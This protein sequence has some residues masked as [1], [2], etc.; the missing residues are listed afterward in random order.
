MDFFRR[1][2]L[3]TKIIT[4]TFLMIFFVVIAAA[5]AIDRVILPSIEND[6]HSEAWRIAN[7]VFS[8]LDGTFDSGNENIWEKR[9]APVFAV[10]PKLLYVEILQFR[11]R[12]LYWAGDRKYRDLPPGKP[13][14]QK[15]QDTLSVKEIKPTGLIYEIV[16]YGSKAAPF[17]S[18]WH[19]RVGVNATVLQQ[20]STQLFRVLFGLTLILLLVSFFLIRWFSGMITRP[21]H[22]LLHMTRL[23]AREPPE[24]ISRFTQEHPPCW[25]GK[26]GGFSPL[27]DSSELFCP[28][29]PLFGPAGKTLDD[30][31]RSRSDALCSNCTVYHQVGRDE[32]SQLLFTFQCMAAGIRVYQEKLKKRYEFEERLLD[33]CPDGIMANDRHG[34][35]ILYNR[36]AENLL[37]YPAEE[38]VNRLSVTAIYRHGEP[39]RIKETLMGETHGGPGVLLDYLTEI[40]RKDGSVVPIRLSATIVPHEAEE[41]AVVG[42][43]HDLTEV[44]HHMNALRELNQR[45]DSSNRELAHLNRHYMEMLGFVTHELK[46]PIAN[47]FM[48]ANA[49]RQEIFGPLSAEQAPMLTSICRNLTQSMEMIR[50]YLDLSRIEKDELPIQP[51]SV[52]L[53]TEI[54]EPVVNGF[55]SR[56]KER[57]TSLL[58]EV[59]EDLRWTL[60]PELFSGVLTNLLSNALNYG[61]EGGTI[62]ISARIME[63]CLR[64]EV[65]NS[66]PGI[67]RMDLDRL[68]KKFQRLPAVRSSLT[69]GTGLGLFITKA[70]VERHGGSI[71]AESEP[72]KWANFIIELPAATPLS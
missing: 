56:L 35:I 33:A 17:E 6:L 52:S 36:G 20:W 30:H 29:C 49:L 46:A 61:E 50:H 51:R 42:Y 62:R 13:T 14:V 59:A 38:V 69:R 68:F 32:L 67:P 39:Q 44:T 25:S 27:S 34:T 3:Q 22:Q 58:I 70:V 11:D 24:N 7:G 65:W 64:I 71:T 63:G 28:A 45:L 37:G 48:C 54:V 26:Q 10:R 66:G 5:V 43:F 31:R 2:N 21:V 55:T 1:L 12:P 60:D 57:D 41:F 16:L 72:G 9:L 40:I 23:L 8:Q 53:L 4:V 18:G 47:A 19:V 15:E